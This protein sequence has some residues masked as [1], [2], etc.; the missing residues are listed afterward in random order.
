VDV[1][2]VWHMYRPVMARLYD[3]AAPQPVEE[4]ELEDGEEGAAPG[5]GAAGQVQ[6]GGS[7]SRMA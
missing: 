5:P 1:E 7:S 6:L 3:A 2:A 4:G